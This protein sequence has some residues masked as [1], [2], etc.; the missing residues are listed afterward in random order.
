MKN[1]CIVGSIICYLDFYRMLY[2]QKINYIAR[3][4]SQFYGIVLYFYRY[5]SKFRDDKTHL[6]T[7][8]CEKMA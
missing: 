6:M 5:R 7:Y 8:A 3:S 2:S 4:Y 1:N